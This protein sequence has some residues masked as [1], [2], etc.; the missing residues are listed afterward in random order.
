MRT[1]GQSGALGWVLAALVFSLC[2][3]AEGRLISLGGFSIRPYLPL[4]L[5]AALVIATRA[6][7]TGYLPEVPAKGS[8]L[9]LGALLATAGLS[10]FNAEYPAQAIKQAVFLAG[11]IGLYL[12]LLLA[13]LR[14]RDLRRIHA[15]ILWS[16][17]LAVA[18]AFFRFALEYARSGSVVSAFVN[19]QGFFV[20]RNEFGLF[21]VYATGFLLPFALN[22]EAPVR[23]KVL[24]AVTLVALL[25]NF[26]RGSLLAFTAMIVADRLG[27]GRVFS[28]RPAGRS[29]LALTGM[30]LVAAVAVLTVLPNLAGLT[31]FLDILISRS[32]GFGAAADETTSIRLLFIRTAG[33]AFLNHPLVGNGIGNVGYVLNQ[34]GHAADYGTVTFRGAIQPPVYELGTTSN[35]FADVLLETGLFGL[36]AFLA[37]LVAVFR[38]A[39]VGRPPHGRNGL[40]HTGALLSAIGILI[41][42]LSYNSIYLPFTWV[43]LALAPLLAAS[44][45]TAGRS[46]PHSVPPATVA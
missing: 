19:F 32:L 42:G 39:I 14:P 22:D 35:I 45:R 6:V 34:F 4:F 8:V 9:A 40:M 12:V 10:I 15:A 25:L 33:R 20:E 29:L 5:V 37:F 27:V 16:L 26:S 28:P 21:M 13:E 38:A 43:S 24:L 18:Y 3:G 2:L 31:N 23:Y 7:R 30:G 11:M 46:A 44:L 17:T 36:L 1:D 41:N